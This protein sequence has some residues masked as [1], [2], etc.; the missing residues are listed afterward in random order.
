MSDDEFF[1]LW[2]RHLAGIYFVASLQTKKPWTPNEYLHFGL[3]K[4]KSVEV[5]EMTERFRAEWLKLT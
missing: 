5:A 3:P 4:P 1:R 2:H